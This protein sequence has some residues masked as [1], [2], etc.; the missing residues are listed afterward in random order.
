MWQDSAKTAYFLGHSSPRMVED[1]Y[2]RG[3]RQNEAKAFWA[4]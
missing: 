4:L 2:A 1:R 3:V